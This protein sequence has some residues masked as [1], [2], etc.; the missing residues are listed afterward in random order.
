[1]LRVRTLGGLSIERNGELITG[2]G[3]QRR[4]LALLALLAKGSGDLG[5]SREKVATYLWPE[6]DDE[7]ARNSLKQ[8]LSVL[9]REL[10][11]DLLLT[12]APD[13]R[14]NPATI[15]SDVRD[16]ELALE[17]GDLEG[18]VALYLGVFLDGFH[19]GADAE[20]FERWTDAE[21]SRLARSFVSSLETLAV[22]A[23]T[24]GDDRAALDWWGRAA[25][26][27]PLNSRFALALIEALL[28]VGDRAGASRHVSI[29]T[30][31]VRRELGEPVDPAIERAVRETPLGPSPPVIY[32]LRAVPHLA[33]A[34]PGP[35][36]ALPF[37]IVGR[38]AALI[39]GFVL[40]VSAAGF[41]ALRG[42]PSPVAA[43][44]AVLPFANLGQA[45]DASFAAG[46]TDELTT[47]IA[48]RGGLEVVSQASAGRYE[49][50]TRTPREIGRELGVAY[51]L[52]GGI[53]WSRG[54]LGKGRV[55]I[56]PKLV[57]VADDQHVWADV[58]E[59]DAEDLFQLQSQVAEH[60]SRALNA[61]VGKA[62]DSTRP[63]PTAN[64]EAYAYYLRGT[65]YLERYT[66][67]PQNLQ[68][69]IE[70]YTR[71]VRLD[72]KF[73][74]AWAKL[75]NA[76][77]ALYWRGYDTRPVRAA[78]AKTTAATA[79]NLRP[80]LPEARMALGWYYSRIQRDYARALTEF[81]RAYSVNP[82]NSQLLDA[83]GTS[84][85]RLGLYREAAAHL[86]RAVALDPRSSDIAMM[87]GLVHSYLRDYPQADRY[88]DRAVVLE[89]DWALPYAAKAQ[90]QL[91]WRGDTARAR[92]IIRSAAPRVSVADILGHLG[93]YGDIGFAAFL[94]TEDPLL[95][96]RLA[97]LT[98][99]DFARFPYAEAGC[100]LTRAYM[101][102]SR[103]DSL[104]ERAFSDSAQAL[105]EV[106]SRRDPHEDLLNVWL[107]LARAG[108]GDSAGAA[109][110]AAQ[111][112][113]NRPRDSDP[114]YA[115]ER[116]TLL[117]QLYLRIGDHSRAVAELDW[118][119]REPSP[120][121][122][123]AIQVD[124]TWFVLRGSP[125]FE[126]LVGSPVR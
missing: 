123:E 27:E 42:A 88:F 67:D 12:G 91:A 104:A 111:S 77:S 26:L 62:A 43:R 71:A 106:L 10:G 63:A 115:A 96:K 15:S 38:W 59:S 87:S 101:A 72:P 118:L 55:R 119:V 11:G 110:A 20:E 28:A 74:L 24:R 17:Q 76:H 6:S 57:R 105:L 5:I 84:E 18:A 103:Q 22:A 117:A 44:M 107:G 79:L 48:A 14:L 51:V 113:A 19:L 60:I 100:L 61:R 33:G 125:G 52:E 89:P 35:S 81:T 34:R 25:T 36:P 65:S 124:P 114:A 49:G 56:T 16:F 126:R 53:L 68:T 85:R 121:S 4:R 30:E 73:A 9:R 69:A 31:L 47:Q 64:L 32:P 70:L 2:P 122:A 21:R 120:L 80:D 66:Y 82:Y 90:L 23:T 86:A 95:E 39:G 99:K 29:H 40:A 109:G 112:L 13:L 97:R 94:V 75:S 50:S 93:Y 8:A 46:L 92:S 78:W 58:F 41:F 116:G 83:M 98:P 54:A 3:V 7:G 108:I 45:G 102:W 1:M 37:S